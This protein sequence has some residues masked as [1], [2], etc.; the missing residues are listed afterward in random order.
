VLFICN[1]FIII[2][3]HFDYSRQV[4]GGAPRPLRLAS[5]GALLSALS[6]RDFLPLG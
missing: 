1:A 6:S 5:I 4:L 3:I 2:I